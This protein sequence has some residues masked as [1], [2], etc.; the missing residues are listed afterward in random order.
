MAPALSHTARRIALVIGSLQGGG[1]ER[2]AG[3]LA[4]GWRG[5]GHAVDL[6]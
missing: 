6:V 1:A 5:R 3:I 2:V 4:Q